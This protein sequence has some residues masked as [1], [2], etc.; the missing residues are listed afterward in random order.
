MNIKR[1]TTR[2]YFESFGIFETRYFGDRSASGVIG[3]SYSGIFSEN[4]DTIAQRWFFERSSC[5]S[6][7]WEISGIFG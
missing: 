1:R 2:N 7:C 6:N 3:F 5:W 4:N